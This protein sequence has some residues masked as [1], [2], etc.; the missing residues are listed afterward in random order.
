V[1]FVL[2]LDSNGLPLVDSFLAVSYI[3]IEEMFHCATKAKYA[4][5]YYIYLK[6]HVFK[7]E[8]LRSVTNQI[9]EFP[10]ARRRKRKSRILSTEVFEVHC[11]CQMT[12]DGCKMVCCNRCNKWFHASCV[13]YCDGIK[14]WYCGECSKTHLVDSSYVTNIV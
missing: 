8:D 9:K 13:D 3:A 6:I 4:Y 5:V 7:K 10:S 14:L 2:P 1:G 12:D 11:I